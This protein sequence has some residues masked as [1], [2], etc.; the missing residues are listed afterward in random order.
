MLALA[1]LTKDDD[2]ASS[3]AETLRILALPIVIAIMEKWMSNGTVRTC[4]LLL[5]NHSESP[6]CDIP[7]SL[8]DIT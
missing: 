3:H 2:V 5:R 1:G 7:C 8:Q 6:S 4:T